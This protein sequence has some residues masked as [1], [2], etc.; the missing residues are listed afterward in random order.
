MRYP[1]WMHSLSAYLLI[2]A[3]GIQCKAIPSP[4]AAGS[5]LEFK[6][7][8]AQ[9][10]MVPRKLPL[11]DF[12]LPQTYAGLLKLSEKP[13]ETE[14]LFFWFVPTENLAAQR[15]LALWTNGGP[16]CSSLLGAFQE[17][18]PIMWKRGSP[19]ATLNPN[20]W[21]RVSHM[22]YL[23]HP[24]NVGFSTGKVVIN[25]EKQV[26]DYMF[27]FLT[28]FL[29]IFPELNSAN[30]YL[31]GES[32]A[33]MYLSYTANLIYTRQSELAL[34]LQGV[35][36]IDAVLSPSV[37]QED[38]PI[39][40]FVKLHQDIFKLSPTF[41]KELETAHK[42]CGYAD[43]LEKF[44]KY[45]APGKFPDISKVNTKKECQLWDKVSKVV[46]DDF[47]FYNIYNKDRGVDPLF[48]KHTYLDRP[49]V[50]KAL[51]VAN[52][53][54]W[55]G[56]SESKTIFPDND[57][58]PDPSGKVLPNVIAKSKRTIVAHGKFDGRL[59]IQGISLGLQSMTW[60]GK[61]GFTKPIDVDFK[62]DGKSLGNF[63]TERGLTYVQV[64]E[65]GHM[66]PQDAPVAALA[67][68]EYLLGNRA[69]L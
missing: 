15:N 27:K 68:F 67:I 3:F 31:T 45:P 60:A 28:N 17:N 56:C 26:A 12:L 53:P 50:R 44:L 46:P 54:P 63:R 43:Y 64:S 59:P 40:P 65:A 49:D 19:K 2:F 58:S 20:S 48:S 55:V 36:F 34:K 13:D 29:K 51:N 35:L 30:F 9:K 39:Y 37:F 21:S 47:D 16:G 11:M 10:Y 62:V 23:E 8:A 18:G 38:V 33:G 57:S 66:I 69:S 5:P 7:A 41:M 4:S 61:Q 24:V 22:L 25:N 52:A 1:T 14:Q 6:S 32:Y 42:T